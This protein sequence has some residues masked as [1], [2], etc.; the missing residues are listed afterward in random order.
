MDGQFYVQEMDSGSI[1]FSDK[2]NNDIKY[3]ACH[4][5]GEYFLR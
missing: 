1:V 3:I 4:L 5:A 2:K